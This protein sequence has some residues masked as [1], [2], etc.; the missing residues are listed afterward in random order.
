MEEQTK[1]ERTENNNNMNRKFFIFYL[2]FGRGLC[3]IIS[4]K[5]F[6]L[7]VVRNRC[8]VL[9]PVEPENNGTR[10]ESERE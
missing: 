7:Y 8:C 2:S 6:K 9:R 5:I 4:N 10:I 3:R 1:T